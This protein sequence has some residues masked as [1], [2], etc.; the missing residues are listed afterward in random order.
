MITL[1]PRLPAIAAEQ[2][3]ERFLADGPEKWSGFS[4]VDLPDMVRFAA[5]GGH[6][7]STTQLDKLRAGVLEVASRNGFGNQAAK[8][9]YAAFD[10]EAA[11]W[12]SEHELLSSGEALRADFWSFMAIA[13]APDIVFWRFGSK[14]ER[15]IGGIRNTF[16]RLWTR[17]KALDRGYEESERWFLLEKLTEDALVQITERPSISSHPIL[18][19]AIAE[20]WVR[21]EQFHGRGKMEDMMRRA[22][23]QIRILNEIRSLSTLPTDELESVL[24]SA[25]GVDP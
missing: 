13:L 4:S 22:I 24:D 23:L 3:L 12:L 21:A 18:A 15:Y 8:G 2:L 5:T 10:A 14:K 6:Q 11:A 1:L 16:Q 20:A 17:G 9:N 19:Q 25:F 7:I